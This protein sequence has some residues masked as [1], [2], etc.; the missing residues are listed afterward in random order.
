VIGPDVGPGDSSGEAVLKKTGIIVSVAAAGVLGL[1]GLAFATTPHHDA[2]SSTTNVQDGNVGNDCAFGQDGPELAQSLTG[3]DNT[4]GAAGLV[5]GIA[6]PITAQTQALNCTN[7]SNSSVSND[8]S[9]ND[10]RTRTE[11]VTR[12]SNND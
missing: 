4:V 6:A 2:P 8:N 5:T 7:I 11:T 3:G 1:G 10:V 12:D 9:G